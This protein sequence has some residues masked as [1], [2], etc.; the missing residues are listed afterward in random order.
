[1]KFYVKKFPGCGW[2]YPDIMKNRLQEA[3]PGEYV[4]E[5]K[6]DYR[7]RSNPQNKYYWGVVIPI[8]LEGL[9]GVGYE[10]EDEEDAHEVI[11]SLFFTKKIKRKGR[12]GRPSELKI[13]GSTAKATTQEFEV[14]M[15]QIR[16]WGSEF[17]G[18]Y[19]PEPNEN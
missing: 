14:R 7:Q 19:I 15:E 11:K 6:R 2:A 17:L 9:R 8:V 12:I 3:K 18:I 13:S 5:V 10:V 1:M 4:W 16:R